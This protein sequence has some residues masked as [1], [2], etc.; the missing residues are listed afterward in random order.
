MFEALGLVFFAGVVYLFLIV[1]PALVENFSSQEFKYAYFKHLS[2]P[3]LNSFG[4]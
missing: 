4:R 2:N 1:V 3:H